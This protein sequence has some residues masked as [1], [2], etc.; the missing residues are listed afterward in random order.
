MA[1]ATEEQVILL[2]RLRPGTTEQDVRGSPVY[3]SLAKCAGPLKSH[4]SYN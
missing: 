2:S 4:F 1:L 3:A